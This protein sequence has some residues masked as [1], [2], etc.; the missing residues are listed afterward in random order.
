M[1]KITSLFFLQSFV[2]CNLVI[3]G[4]VIN[5]N[6]G[7]PISQVNVVEKSTKIGAITDDLGRFSIKTDTKENVEITFSHIGFDNHSATFNQDQAEI[8]I[9]LKES[10]LLMDDIVVT[11]TRN[12]HLLRNVPV[13]TEVIGKREIIE[14]GAAT[15]SDILLQRSGVSASYNVDGSPI[16]KMLGLEQKHILVLQDGTPITGK[17]N[18]QID[19]SQIAA[20]R[21]EKIEIIK[22]PCSALYGSDAM[23]GV[24]NI[25]TDRSF[26]NPSLNLSYREISY[27][28]SLNDLL[29]SKSSKLIKSESALPFKNLI[30]TNDIT[31]QKF[32]KNSEI[33]YLNADNI[34]KFNFNTSFLWKINNH[35]I[36]IGHQFYRQ[37]NDESIK[38]FNGTLVSSNETNINRN[39]IKLSYVYNIDN[40]LS[41]SQSLRGVDYKRGYIVKNALAIEQSNDLTK[42]EDLEYKFWFN[43]KYINLNLDGGFEFSNPRYVSDR[44]KNG[45]QKKS[46]ASIF[47]QTTYN[48]SQSSNFI[49]GLRY[50]KYGGETI[51]SPRLA[52]AF[53]KNERLIYRLSYSHGFRTPSFSERFIDWENTQVGYSIKGNPNLVPEVSKGINLG[54][55]ITNQSN[56]QINSLLHYTVFSNLI[57]SFQKEPSIF[58]YE[59]IQ[60]AKIQGIEIITKW[61]ITNSLTS[62]FTMNFV[63]SKDRDGSQ[64][65]GTLPISFGGRLSYTPNNEKTLI[66]INLK[67]IGSHTP[68]EY[69][70]SSGE[71]NK[72][73]DTIKPYIISDVKLNFKINGKNNLAFGM[74]NLT[75]HTD[76]KFG[77]YIG[78]AGYIEISTNLEK[79]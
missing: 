34:N 20:N 54:F 43:K 8:V 44:L 66:S 14:S 49:T 24:V 7:N 48:I 41:L 65:P 35:N 13:A 25:I 70:S 15:L 51:I 33:E 64:L 26:Q 5:K 79:E 57:K 53:R 12:G 52:F 39:Q 2:Y 68:M 72:A 11:S 27:S 76:A 10:V 74:T 28:K 73:S 29:S 16:F 3:S 9:N 77:P 18:N 31:F 60:K 50:D 38:L 37:N 47:T 69:N 55:E 19:L 30:V 62:K 75:N 58:M 17:F 59:N 63:Q 56:F 78:R 42:E 4:V 1:F 46:I 21:I 67:G 61:V 22:G 71:Y 36:E 45:E 32:S 23:G 40:T 6:N